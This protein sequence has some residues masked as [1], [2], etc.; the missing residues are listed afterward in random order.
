MKRIAIIGGGVTGLT[1]ALLLLEQGFEVTL[2]EASGAEGGLAGSWR[3]DGFVFDFGPH[4]FCTD[5]PALHALLQRV[6]G[7]DLLEIEKRTAQYF[8]GK[9]VRYPFEIADVLK[10]VSPWLCLRALAEVGAARLR[11]LFREPPGD[12]F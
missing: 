12:S 7:D 8:N 1:T 2:Y 10:N 4:E 3:R 9:Y 5:N 11:N 6:C